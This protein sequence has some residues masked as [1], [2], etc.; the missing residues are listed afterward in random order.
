MTQSKAPLPLRL[1][2]HAFVTTD[3]A[4]T[5][6]FYED[7]IGLPLIATWTEVEDLLGRG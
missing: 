4:A 2:H 7:I 6:T 5:R 3:Q 1:H